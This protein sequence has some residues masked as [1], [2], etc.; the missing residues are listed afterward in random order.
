MSERTNWNLFDTCDKCQQRTGEACFDL[1]YVTEQVTCLFRVTPHRNRG[2]LPSQRRSQATDGDPLMAAILSEAKRQ[3]MSIL[4]LSEAAEVS[5][6]SLSS[7]AVGATSPRLNML[8][9]L[10]EAIDCDIAVVPRVKEN[11]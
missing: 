3:G 6:S 4:S 7:N 1:R 2:R 11:R 5:H 8:R 9:K 10:L